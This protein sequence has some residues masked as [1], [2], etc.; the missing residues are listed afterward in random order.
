MLQAR[1][2][3]VLRRKGKQRKGVG[4]VGV[5]CGEGEWAQ[6]CIGLAWQARLKDVWRKT[7]KKLE[8][9]VNQQQQTKDLERRGHL[10]RLWRSGSRGGDMEGVGWEQRG[11]ERWLGSVWGLRLFS[12]SYLCYFSSQN[13][14][15]PDISHIHLFIYLTSLFPSLENRLHKGRTLYSLSEQPLTHTGISILGNKFTDERGEPRT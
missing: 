11:P 15:L 7:R 2:C 13:L 6:F 3:Q 4:S 8:E 1:W 10:A 5:G 9:Q 12:V 14:T